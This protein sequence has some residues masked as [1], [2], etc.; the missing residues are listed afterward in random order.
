M[1]ILIADDHEVVLHGLRDLLRTH[2]D[3]EVCGEARSGIEAVGLARELGPNL[4]ILDFS[5]P[6]LNGL[7]ATRQI[8]TALPAVDVLL[9]SVHDSE[10]LAAEALEAGARGWVL[11]SR[12][13]TELIAAVE[14]AAAARSPAPLPNGPAAGRSGRRQ[15]A[16]GALTSRQRQ[17]VQLV[18]EGKS[19][20]QT[21]EVLGISARTVETHR[22][23][24]MQRLGL[25]SVVQLVRYAIRNRIVEA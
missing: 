24:I 18:A 2:A 3:W 1:R 11:K 23:H 25:S 8:R 4:A 19:N 9:F 12:A 16:G 7:E 17:I 14:A 5:M 10:Q 22:A 20:E 13:A 15:A 21:A 6:L